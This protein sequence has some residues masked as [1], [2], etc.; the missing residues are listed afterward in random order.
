MKFTGRAHTQKRIRKDFIDKLQKSN[1]LSMH[2]T[3][4]HKNKHQ[5]KNRGYSKR[6]EEK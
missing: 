3:T 2:G 4:S 5:N 6:P 1:K